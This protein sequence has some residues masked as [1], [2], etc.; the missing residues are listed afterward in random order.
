MD[1][2]PRVVV[3][4]YGNA[5]RS[6][7]SY[8]VGLTPG[9]ELY[10]ACARNPETR[11][12]IREERDCKV[13]GSFDEVLADPNVDLVVLATPSHLHAEGAIQAMRAGKHVVTDKPAACTTAEFD[14]MVAVSQETGRVLSV[15]HNR[16]WDGDYFTVRRIMQEGRI[17]RVTRIEMNWAFCRMPAGWR[18]VAETAGGRV[19]DLGS[20]MI[21]QLCLLF[22]QAI[23]SVYAKLQYESA[24]HNV[25]SDAVIIVNFEDNATGIVQTGGISHIDKPRFYLAGLDGT[26]VKY[27]VDPQEVVMKVGDIDAAVEL[28]ELYG[29][30][31]AADSPETETIPTIPGRWRS[32]Y[33]AVAAEIA[34]GAAAAVPLDTV[35]RTMRVLDAAFESARTGQVVQM[36]ESGDDAVKAAA[37]LAVLALPVDDIATMK[38]E[39]APSASGSMT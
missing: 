38:T 28:P 10:G 31:K 22:P 5:G 12:R 33:E 21:D 23:T 2:L 4:G 9:L 1:H 20:H 25:E 14:Q 29:Q 39:L 35:R 18:G 32:Y 13:Y 11:A 7:H 6:F 27:G 37:E 8:L 30:L 16:R 34:D 3:I 19:Y 17:G 36:H 24:D 15:F 26:F